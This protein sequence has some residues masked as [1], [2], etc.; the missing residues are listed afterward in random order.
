MD[1]LL[2]EV[3]HDLRQPLSV[4]EACTGLL[5]RLP[6]PE[7]AQKLVTQIQ[8]AARRIADLGDELLVG[9]GEMSRQA[10]DLGEVVQG[11]CHDLLVTHP[12]RAIEVDSHLALGRWDRRRVSRIVQNLLENAL[13]HGE[14]EGLVLVSCGSSSGQAW[15]S[16]ENRSA[17][18]KPAELSELFQ[19]FHRG[20]AGGRAGLGLHIAREMARAHGGELTAAWSGGWIA[21]RLVLP[22]AET[23]PIYT[24]PRRHMRARLDSEL[25]V[26]IGERVFWAQGRDISQ[27][28]LAFVADVEL[29]VSDR[30]K[31]AVYSDSGSFSVLGTV[32]HVRRAAD[33]VLV[34]VEFAGDLSQ[35][36]LE[37]LKKRRER[38][39]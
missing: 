17:E 13:L 19:P 25:E 5:L 28:G 30:I 10:F 26:A 20:G 2:A 29:Q 33:D 8:A 16:V 18:I 31:L 22:T 3:A 4:I 35:A 12:G 23:E 15:L 36:E 21:F 7:R 24:T 39:S 14:S 1:R 34:G 11:L 27:R 6:L 38:P 9:A 37:I 32:R